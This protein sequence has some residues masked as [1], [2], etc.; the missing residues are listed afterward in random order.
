MI[1]YLIPSYITNLGIGKAYNMN[2]IRLPKPLKVKMSVH[3][4]Y[5]KTVPAALW[6]AKNK[7]NINLRLYLQPLA[8]YNSYHN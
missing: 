6:M 3:D 2:P 4:I 1:V 5:A 8:P 7:R